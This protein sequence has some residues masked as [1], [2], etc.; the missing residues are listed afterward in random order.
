MSDQ[1]I[2]VYFGYI[3]I[4]SFLSFDKV[5]H[6]S[7]KKYPIQR[8]NIKVCG[9]SMKASG[10]AHHQVWKQMGRIWTLDGD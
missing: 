4:F 5:C 2:S 8:Y 6:V 3:K 1:N 7:K 10:R 9:I